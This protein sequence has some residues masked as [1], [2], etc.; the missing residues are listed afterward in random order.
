MKQAQAA[1]AKD[2]FR[3]AFLSLRVALALNSS[4][5]A[6]TRLMADLFDRGQSPAA[7]GWRRRV[8]EL[9]PSLENKIIFAAC[10]L[11]YEKPPFPLSLQTL[12][13][14]HPL[15]E[16]NTAYHLVASQL[17]LRLN[18]LPDAESHLE[19]AVRLDPTNRLH[20]LNLATVRLQSVDTNVAVR[21]RRELAALATDPA[22][23]LPA[24]RSLTADGLARHDVAAA[25]DS[26]RQLQ[27]QREATLEDC[28]LRLTVLRESQ[29]A[30]LSESLARVQRECA[31]NALKVARAVSWMNGHGLA[32]PGLDW[33]ASLPKATR[34]TMPVPLAE[35]ECC[36]TLADWPG[37]Q[38]RLVGRRWEEQEFLRLACLA[39][40]LR[41]QN[42]RDA[43]GAN[44][45]LALSAAS[46]RAEQLLVLLQATRAWGW[47][48]ETADVL[49]A[50]AGRTRAEDW[51]LRML[52]SDYTAKDDT[53]GIYR[54]YQ[55]LLERHPDS[56]ELKNNVATIGLLLGRDL[57]RSQLLA[58]EIYVAAKT[59]A[60]LVSTYAYALHAQ[61]KTAEGLK[62][63]RGFPERELHRPEIAL[64]YAVMLAASGEQHQAEPYFA[65]AEKGRPLPEE[66]RLLDQARR[67][68]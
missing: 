50:I 32:R 16:T 8:C 28:L 53:A 45:R 64:Y 19:S 34:T 13:A 41:E 35:A 21:A 61:G 63:M 46:K 54:V 33:T 37:L 67:G 17:A 22:L 49:W 27:A 31:T 25:D 23:A 11:R 7:L 2:D 36:V 58:R 55:A 14:L 3:S 66:R 57:T 15:A 1:L 18:H 62:L 40:A 56:A 4:N 26:S 52:M 5:L 44:W 20:Q 38:D 47:T 59:N 9:E 29:S 48:D 42:K 24:L 65:A 39:R 30:Q 68:K 12:E 6:A 51:P 10:A 60:A 43:A